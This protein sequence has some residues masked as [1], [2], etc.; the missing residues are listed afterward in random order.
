MVS[1]ASITAVRARQS[2]RRLRIAAPPPNAVVGEAY[3]EDILVRGGLAPYELTVAGGTLPAGLE[4]D[5]V[6]LSGEPEEAGTAFV[7]FK[8]TDANGTE[9]ESATDISVVEA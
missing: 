2:R 6:T 5:G 1:A 7:T 4:I 8:I 9:R 3:E